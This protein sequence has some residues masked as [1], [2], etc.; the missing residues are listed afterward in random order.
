[1]KRNSL[2]DAY[3]FDP[4]II[5][6]IFYRQRTK[7]YLVYIEVKMSNNKKK[8]LKKE[9]PKTKMRLRDS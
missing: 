2:D 9:P 1:M 6:S 4:S 3:L 8:Q 7:N 5:T